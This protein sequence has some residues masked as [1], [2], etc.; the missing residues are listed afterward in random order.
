VREPKESL[1]ATQ[2]EA[3]NVIRLMTIHHAKGL[4]FP[5]V[6]VPDLDRQ[7]LV[8]SPAAALHAELG[9]LVPQPADDDGEKITTGMTLYAALE[10]REELEE[11]KRLLYVACT[12]AA[13]YLT[14]SASL[15]A[16]DKPKSDWM[17]L[18]AERFDLESRNLLA[19]LPVDFETPQITVTT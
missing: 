12:R 9:P 8:R 11:R 10:R 15:E 7:P 18:L 16:F 6:V 2:P 4:E 5:F 1:A 14:L 13:D 3:A 19:K 17:E